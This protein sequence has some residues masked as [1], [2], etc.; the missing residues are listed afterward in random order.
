MMMMMS[1]LFLGVRA[2]YSLYIAFPNPLSWSIL[3]IFHNSVY[4]SP[5]PGNF[6]RPFLLVSFMEAPLCFHSILGWRE[7]QDISYQG[8]VMCFLHCLNSQVSKP[9]SP[10]LWKFILYS[11]PPFRYVKRW[12]FE[13]AHIWVPFSINWWWMFSVLFFFPFSSMSAFPAL[14]IG[15]RCPP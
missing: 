10:L 6:P 9:W 15:N 2:C 8:I 13:S 5:L 4:T 3:S 7:W 1:F 11:L 12:M 14:G